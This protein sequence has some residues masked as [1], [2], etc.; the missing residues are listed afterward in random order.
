LSSFGRVEKEFVDTP[1]VEAT[2]EWLNGLLDAAE[3]NTTFIDSLLLV[4]SQ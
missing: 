2:K 4:R 1:S 3:G